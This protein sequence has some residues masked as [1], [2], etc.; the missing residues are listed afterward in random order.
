MI[1]KQDSTSANANTV[2]GFILNLKTKQGIAGKLAGPG[3]YVSRKQSIN[4]NVGN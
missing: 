1:H 2:A 4:K 3:R